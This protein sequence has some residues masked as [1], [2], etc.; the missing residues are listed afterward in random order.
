MKRDLVLKIMIVISLV[1]MGL[2]AI[3]LSGCTTNN[4]LIPSGKTVIIKQG[5][6]FCLENPKD[7]IC[8]D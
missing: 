6:D 2:P 1:V 7:S 3:L 8:T 5:K 4:R